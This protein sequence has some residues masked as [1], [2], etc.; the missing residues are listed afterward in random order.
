MK[1][2][3]STVE[4][5]ITG[6]GAIGASVAFILTFLSPRIDAATNQA[7]QAVT[8]ATLAASAVQALQTTVNQMN[9][10]VNALNN[11]QDWM[12]LHNGATPD[13][14]QALSTSTSI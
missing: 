12:L 3:K 14:I 2:D 5:V 6:A 8:S 9:D 13:V 11:K 10:R 1:R 7:N 4:L